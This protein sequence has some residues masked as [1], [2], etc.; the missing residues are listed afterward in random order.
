M[1]LITD[2]SHT[3]Q[4]I[5]RYLFTF[6]KDF[7]YYTSTIYDCAGVNGRKKYLF[8]LFL[9]KGGKKMIFFDDVQKKTVLRFTPATS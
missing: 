6:G 1:T 7:I 4:T 3:N 2:T 5:T 9:K 8:L